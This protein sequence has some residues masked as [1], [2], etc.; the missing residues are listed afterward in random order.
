MT[1]MHCRHAYAGNTIAR[2]DADK[3]TAGTC[4]HTRNLK[5][6]EDTMES[7]D[8]DMADTAYTITLKHKHSPEQKTESPKPYAQKHRQ[9]TTNVHS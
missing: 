4:M 7:K 2:E 3:P 6:A 5:P 1:T 8:A 9:K